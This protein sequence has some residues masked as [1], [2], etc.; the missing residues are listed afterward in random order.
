MAKAKTKKATIILLTMAFLIYLVYKTITSSSPTAHLDHIQQHTPLNQIS[1]QAPLL[2]PFIIH[3]TWKDDSIPSKWLDI[4]SECRSIYSNFQHILWTDIKSR[5]FIN[6][7]YP[8]FLETWDE[9]PQDIQRADAIR[10]FVLYHYGGIY[11]DL[12][13]G[14]AQGKNYTDFFIYQSVLPEVYPV[15]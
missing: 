10:Y 2:V 5:Q 3:Q 9:Y 12:D 8:W 1:N 13:V 4:Y 7:F 15:I 6:D 11:H 14:C